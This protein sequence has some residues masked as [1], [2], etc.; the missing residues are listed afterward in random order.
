MAGDAHAALELGRLLCLTASEPRAPGDGDQSWPEERWLRAAVESRPDDIEA[1][2]LLTGRLAQ[3]ISYW[4]AVLDMNPDVMEDYG[5][6]EATVRRRQIEAEELYARIRAAGPV[7][8]AAEAG[9][10]ELAVLL[11]VSGKP[12]AEAAYSFYVFEDE[13]WSGS[14]RYGTTIVASDA[15]E[16]RWACDEWFALETGL[17]SAPTLTT[18]VDG[19]KVSSIDL[20]RHLVDTAVSWDDVAVPELTGLPL[21]VGLPVPGHGLYYGFTSAAE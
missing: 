17:S 21:P 1:L 9:L 20:G 11:G 14:V 16:I 10:D 13:A 6:D 3:Q 8:P 4:E 19:A 7:G 12:A 2:T 15:D 5:E 18:Y